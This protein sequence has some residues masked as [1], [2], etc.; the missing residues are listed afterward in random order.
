MAFSKEQKKMWRDKPG[1]KARQREYKRLW[2]VDNEQTQFGPMWSK[3]WFEES[4]RNMLEKKALSDAKK[5]EVEASKPIEI[6]GIMPR[7]MTKEQ[8]AIMQRWSHRNSHSPERRASPEFK[9]RARISRKRYR[10]SPEVVAR[11]RARSRS[12]TKSLRETDIEY[13]LVHQLR[14]RLRGVFTTKKT[15]AARRLIGCDISELRKHLELQFIGCMSWANYGTAWEIDHRVPLA[16]F[17]L[18]TER[19]QRECFHFTNLRPLWKK[20]NR[21]RFKKGV[22]VQQEI[23]FAYAA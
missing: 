9:D 12:R 3:T 8:R 11:R 1:V 13:R 16:Y 7:D 4:E 14:N 15:H 10:P 18:S 6:R 20:T 19:G 5:E 17:D 21:K 22:P 2:K 23:P